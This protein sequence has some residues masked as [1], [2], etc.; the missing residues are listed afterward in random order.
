MINVWL[1]D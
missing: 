1:F